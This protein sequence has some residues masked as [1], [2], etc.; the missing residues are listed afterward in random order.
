[1][2]MDCKTTTD[3]TTRV[4][5]GNAS[6]Q[7]AAQLRSH[8]ATCASCA[9]LERRILRTWELM[10]QLAPV[11]SKS[12]VPA[13][14]RKLVSPAWMVGAAAAAVLVISALAF[15]L[16]KP[17][18]KADPS[19]PVAVQQSSDEARPDPR[20][21]EKPRPGRPHQDRHRNHRGSHPR[22]SSPAARRPG[23]RARRADA[24]PGAQDSGTR[25]P[26]A[27]GRGRQ[28]PA[29]GDAARREDRPRD[30]A[31][32][33]RGGRPGHRHARPRRRRRSR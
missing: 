26:R 32:P 30:Q 23:T 2:D 1:M 15:S 29:G 3:L 5:S 28:D 11:V 12:P 27:Q 20:D 6:T 31:G 9:D 10:G 4:V 18:P 24:E 7:D 19:S 25:R 14:P 17:G 16:F 33:G 22:G 21:E 8:V 13:A